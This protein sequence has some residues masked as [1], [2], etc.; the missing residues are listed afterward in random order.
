[1]IQPTTCYEVTCDHCGEYLEL[2]G[3]TAWSSIFDAVD[4]INYCGWRYRDEELCVYC[5]NCEEYLNDEPQTDEQV[6]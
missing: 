2:D 1:M 4:A 5:P 3:I 6:S